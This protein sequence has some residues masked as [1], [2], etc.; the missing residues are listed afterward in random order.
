M[1]MKLSEALLE[2]MSMIDEEYLRQSEAEKKQIFA[3]KPFLSFAA[4]CVLMMAAVLIAPR[5]FSS[6]SG[7]ASDM[8]Y[9]ETVPE[10]EET[11]K[12]ANTE[13]DSLSGESAV[14]LFDQELSAWLETLS[15]EDLIEVTFEQFTT[16]GAPLYSSE[17]ITA[18]TNSWE[19]ET[20]NV[21][22]LTKAELLGFEGEEGITYIF[23][24]YKADD[25][26]Q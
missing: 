4:V 12:A 3:W 23:H 8:S 25:M 24:L 5:Y 11:S 2:S 26:D 15:D 14:I 13:T 7:A 10:I 21:L 19:A 18:D 16:E 6:E 22:T 9:V 17:M 1:V 20:E